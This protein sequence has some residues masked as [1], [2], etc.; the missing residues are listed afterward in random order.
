MLLSV[1]HGQP[2]RAGAGQKSQ[3][4]NRVLHL[5]PGHA[6]LPKPPRRCRYAGGER[7]HPGAPPRPPQELHILKERPRWK[8]AEAVIARTPHR[9]AL[10]AEAR[11]DGIETREPRARAQERAAI[12]EGETKR[13]KLHLRPGKA[14][15]EHGARLAWEERVGVEE[16]QHLTVRVDGARGALPAT[17]AWGKDDAR[18]GTGGERGRGIGAAAVGDDDFG[19]GQG[20]PHGVQRGDDVVR[21]VERGND[22][23]DHGAGVLSSVSSANSASAFRPV[24]SVSTSTATALMRVGDPP[25]WRR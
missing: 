17:T 12:V 23:G 18:A 4:Q 7:P 15:R 10:I 9:D 13:A 21:L 11:E 1:G 5:L 24:L 20:D 6:V 8:P 16:E 2:I 25:K 3:Q 14:A 19:V 22:D